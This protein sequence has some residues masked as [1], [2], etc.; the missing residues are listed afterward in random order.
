MLCRNNDQTGGN[1]DH[2]SPRLPHRNNI[3]ETGAR[4]QQGRLSASTADRHDAGYLL[5]RRP[6]LQ[7][8]PCSRAR[9]IQREHPVRAQVDEDDLV[10]ESSRDD[11]RIGL[12][13]WR[14]RPIVA[15]ALGR[16]SLRTLMPNADFF[17]SLGLFVRRGFLDPEASLMLRE[18]VREAPAA[19][20]IVHTEEGYT[21]S[22]GRYEVWTGR[23]WRPKRSSW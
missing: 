10:V 22:T 2:A 4:H 17:A 9:S 12:P 18:V 6:R 8:L 5:R 3:R 16:Y 20:A 19:P 13:A 11:V 7:E 1:D 21:T 14:H 23:R 15:H